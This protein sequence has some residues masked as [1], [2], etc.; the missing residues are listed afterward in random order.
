MPQIPVQGALNIGGTIYQLD[1]TL[2]TIDQPPPPPPPPPPEALFRFTDTVAYQGLSNRWDQ[3][4]G[5]GEGGTISPPPSGLPGT[6]FRANGGIGK[7]LVAKKAD[8]VY[9]IGSRFRAVA[10]FYFPGGSVPRQCY[11]FDFEAD[12]DAGGG[13]SELGIRLRIGDDG[14][15]EVERDKMADLPTVRCRSGAG[16]VALDADLNVIEFE[17][18]LSLQDEGDDAG[19]MIVRLNGDEVLN[20][21]GRTLPLRGFKGWTAAGYNRLQAGLTANGGSSTC[22]VVMA[23]LLWDIR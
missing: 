19:E 1:G 13:S 14:R 6:L 10:G 8:R 9:G 18:L 17:V 5:P 12:R 3:V 2:A 23:D 22:E 20:A 11:L 7:A 21:R 4:R 15:I 16:L